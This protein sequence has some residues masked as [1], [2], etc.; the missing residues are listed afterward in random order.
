MNGLL[1]AASKFNVE[2][3]GDPNPLPVRRVCQYMSEWTFVNLSGT[4]I[5]RFLLPSQA[6]DSL[7]RIFLYIKRICYMAP[8][9][10]QENLLMAGGYHSS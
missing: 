1:R 6:T 4:A 9:V 3:D 8:P 5:I 7:W 10:M 2:A